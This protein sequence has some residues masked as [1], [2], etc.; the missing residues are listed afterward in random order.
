[1]AKICSSNNLSA[2]EE[3]NENLKQVLFRFKLALYSAD[4]VRL[5]DCQNELYVF[6]WS[7]MESLEL[8]VTDYDTLHNCIRVEENM[9]V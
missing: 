9:K 4:D 5:K 2:F 6:L 3:L 1:M 8:C 7:V